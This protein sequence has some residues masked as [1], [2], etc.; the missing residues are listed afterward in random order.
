M[1]PATR[2]KIIRWL[3]IILVNILLIIGGLEVL[4]RTFDPLGIWAARRGVILYLEQMITHPTGY[5]IAEGEHDFTWHTIALAD[6]TRYTP[7]SNETSNCTIAVIGD[8]FVYGMGVDDDETL[9]NHI[10]RNHNVRVINTGRIG[11]NAGRVVF[12]RYHYRA[13]FYVYLHVDNDNDPL[14]HYVIDPPRYTLNY[15]SAFNSYRTYVDWF[16]GGFS[17]PSTRRTLNLDYWMAMTVLTQDSRVLTFAF[18][19]AEFGELG[20]LAQNTFQNVIGIGDVYMGH[21]VSAVDYHPNG[22][23]HRRIADAMQP[24][25]DA[26]I[27]I[28]CD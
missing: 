18:D 3:V 2:R 10:A 13:D 9:P 12:L 22:E 19:D 17:I 15:H 16:V 23:G 24:Y 26:A 5:A 21:H 4:L 20:T 11:Y 6:G 27:P 1:S 7:D 8:S 25:I 28:Y 14:D